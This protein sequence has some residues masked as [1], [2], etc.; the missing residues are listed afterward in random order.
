VAARN[1]TDSG[2]CTRVRWE[3]AG[4]GRPFVG[5]VRSRPHAGPISTGNASS[6]G[7]SSCSGK[8]HQLVIDRTTRPRG[9]GEFSGPLDRRCSSPSSAAS[10]DSG[11]G[12]RFP[13][14]TIPRGLRDPSRARSAF[15]SGGPLGSRTSPMRGQDARRTRAPRACRAA[16]H[17][18]GGSATARPTTYSGWDRLVN[19]SGGHRQPA[20]PALPPTE[21]PGRSQHEREEPRRVRDGGGGR[22][23]GIPAGRGLSAIVHTCSNAGYTAGMRTIIGGD[24]FWQCHKLAAGVLRRVAARYGPDIRKRPVTDGLGAP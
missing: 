12:R 19:S 17:R 2:V 18:R 16:A 5:Q 13:R 9:D 11:Y 1:S 22:G 14:P 10:S 7:E 15:P 21:L 4:P 23:G 8:V 3:M 24:Q 6:R 20:E